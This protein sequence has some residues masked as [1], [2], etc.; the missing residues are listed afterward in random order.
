M[1]KYYYPMYNKYGEKT[2]KVGTM[3]LHDWE[4]INRWGAAY[5]KGTNIALFEN[6]DTAYR[7]ASLK[8]VVEEI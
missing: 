7:V 3:Y 1:K 2:G 8:V 4:V 5:K 6:E